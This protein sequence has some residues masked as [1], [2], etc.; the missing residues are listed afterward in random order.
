MQSCRWGGDDGGRD[1]RSRHDG[2]RDNRGRDNRG[3]DVVALLYVLTIAAS[4]SAASH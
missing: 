4:N 1:N 2:G 3:S